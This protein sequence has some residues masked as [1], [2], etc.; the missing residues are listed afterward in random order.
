MAETKKRSAASYKAA[1]KKAAAT[2]RKNS[3]SLSAPKRKTPA[4]RKR[5]K[6]TKKK[7]ILG[8]LGDFGSAENRN[9]FRTM[10]SGGVGGALY[11][12][13]DAQVTIPSETP[14]KKLLYAALGCYVLA[15]AG[16]KPM[17]AAGGIGAAAYDFFKAKGFLEDGPFSSQ[18]ARQQWADPL[19]NIPV[20]LSQDQA[21][22]LQENQ[23]YLQQNGM[24][25]QD[26][27]YLPDYAA[28]YRYP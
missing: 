2:R 12:I 4:A 17:V 20:T 18:V 8:G 27:Q 16:K 13:Y 25:L 6:P 5:R 15:I 23:M 14:E 19:Q 21:M 3:R 22:Y 7:G 28:T 9:A 11:Q 26:Q 1:A 10:I 24:S